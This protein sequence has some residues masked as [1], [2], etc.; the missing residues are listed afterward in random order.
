[1]I[2]HRTHDGKSNKEILV[3][4]ST[5]RRRHWL[6]FGISTMYG[7]CLLVQPVRNFA[8]HQH[9]SQTGPW[10]TNLLHAGLLTIEPWMLNKTYS[11]DSER[12]LA[13][14]L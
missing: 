3:G 7:C 5:A 8:R 11:F 14:L 6:L 1:L 12:K 9:S 13:F 10:P 4:R 2:S